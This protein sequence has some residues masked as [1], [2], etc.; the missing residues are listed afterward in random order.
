MRAEEEEGEELQN[1]DWQTPSIKQTTPQQ[2]GCVYFW[3]DFW[4]GAVADNK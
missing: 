2:Q 3:E 1:L 4:K